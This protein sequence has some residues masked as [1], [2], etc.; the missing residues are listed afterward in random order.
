MSL[1]FLARRAQT[2]YSHITCPFNAYYFA[3]YYIL[4]AHLIHIAFFRH[5]QSFSLSGFCCACAASCMSEMNTYAL[6][7]E[8]VIV[9]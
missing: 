9:G 7:Y 8:D 1:I 2:T 6:A 5:S 4:L 3:I